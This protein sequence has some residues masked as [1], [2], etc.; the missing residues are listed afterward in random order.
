MKKYPYLVLFFLSIVFSSFTIQYGKKAQTIE[1]FS[2]NS[3]NNL[4]SP[5]VGISYSLVPRNVNA[6]FSVFVEKI[7]QDNKLIGNIHDGKKK[8]WEKAE[9]VYEVSLPNGTKIA[10]AAAETKDA[11]E[12]TVWTFRD[13][14]KQKMPMYKGTLEM[15][16]IVVKYLIEKGYL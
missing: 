10:E 7:R 12:V 2:P 8:N 13:N 5:V 11:Q 16:L 15:D 6:P 14:K 1:S 3:Y 4:D 9:L